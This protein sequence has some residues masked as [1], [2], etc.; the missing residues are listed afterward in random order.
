MRIRLEF[1]RGEKMM[2]LSHLDLMRTFGRALRRAEIPVLYSEGFNPH[3]KMVFGLPLQVGVTGEAE[4]LDIDVADGFEAD[5]T[6][7]ILNARLPDG[8]KVSRAR[9]VFT[10]ENAMAIITHAS[11]EM[12]VAMEIDAQN[13]CGVSLEELLKSAVSAFLVPG[14]CIVE[15]T[16]DAAIRRE[17]GR[18]DNHR[19]RGGGRDGNRGVANKKDSRI[20]DLAPLVRSVG[21]RG[22]VVDML[23]T[24]GS[25]NNVKPDLVLKALNGAGSGV[26]HAVFIREKLHRK[27]LYVERDG[28]L[29]KPADEI[30]CGG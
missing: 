2:Y 25:V 6:P 14:R 17:G 24:A 11:Y 21:A 13:G 5:R 28:V 23:V 29:Y 20:M 15:K 4:C 19:R 12:T 26:C 3:A 16:P 8:L 30:I 1:S 18:G 10:N 22:N 27:S 9:E 7:G